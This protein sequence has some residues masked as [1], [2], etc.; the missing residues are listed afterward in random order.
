MNRDV[1]SAALRATAKVA[2]SM[3]V[4]GCSASESAETASTESDI[5]KG[6]PD[7]KNADAGPSGSNVGTGSK[8]DSGP[9]CDALLAAFSAEHE[10]YESEVGAHFADGGTAGDAP[11]PAT[12]STETK[13]CCYDE[14]SKQGFRSPHREA[15]CYGGA[16]SWL[17]ALESGN[18]NIQAACTPWGPP[19]PPAMKRRVVA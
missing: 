6:C 9:S 8:A 13:S 19:V 15:C 10:K 14:V 2:F 7:E 3:A 18:T 5:E 16:L 4:V 1:F 17:E 12:I 11:T